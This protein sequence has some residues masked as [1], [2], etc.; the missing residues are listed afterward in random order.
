MLNFLCRDRKNGQY[1]NHNLND[2]VAHS[3][4]R[5]DASIYPEPA[6]EMINTVKDVDKLVL[7]SACIFSRLGSMSK[8]VAQGRDVGH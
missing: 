7:T 4:S 2:Y 3:P 6:E 5:S 8:W 1:L